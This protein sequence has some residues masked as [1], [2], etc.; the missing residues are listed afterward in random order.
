M[1]DKNFLTK[2][3]KF[4]SFCNTREDVGGVVTS[5]L[6]VWPEDARY[7]S[8][9]DSICKKLH[10]GSEFVDDAMQQCAEE[11]QMYLESLYKSG[12]HLHEFPG[13]GVDIEESLNSLALDIQT[14]YNKRKTLKITNVIRLANSN[15]FVID[16]PS[17]RP[18]IKILSKYEQT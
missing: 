10:L 15:S 8:I 16:I 3:K 13:S 11:V 1:I 14:F 17:V 7:D 5:M 2:F 18:F 12:L 9:V 4:L 6:G